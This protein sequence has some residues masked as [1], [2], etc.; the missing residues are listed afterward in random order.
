MR[1]R[2]G[3]S[4][5]DRDFRQLLLPWCSS[6]LGPRKSCLHGALKSPK[7][8]HSLDGSREGALGGWG[9]S[10]RRPP[11]T[12]LL[13]LALGVGGLEDTGGRHEVLNVLAQNLVL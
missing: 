2:S 6:P 3:G 5:D 13:S 11:T 1:G 4:T 12:T 9:S 10:W 8:R 7:Q